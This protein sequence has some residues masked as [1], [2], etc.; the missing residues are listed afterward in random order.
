MRRQK[1]TACASA[2]SFAETASLT[3]RTPDATIPD[4]N[5]IHTTATKRQS[6]NEVSKAPNR[7]QS[8]GGVRSREQ[9][10]LELHFVLHRASAFPCVMRREYRT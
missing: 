4:N 10:V 6:T 9:R 2:A 8:Q 5:F 3:E 7:N 1:A